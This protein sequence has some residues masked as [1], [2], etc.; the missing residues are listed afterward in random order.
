M[1]ASA[2]MK[3]A[4]VRWWVTINPAR[5]IA[6]TATWARPRPVRGA[7]SSSA[8]SRATMPSSSAGAW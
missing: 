8:V 6:A 4:A 7:R 3:T 1:P 5:Q 2:T